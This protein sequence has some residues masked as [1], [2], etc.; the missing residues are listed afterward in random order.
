[1]TE[2]VIESEADARAAIDLIV[3][4][5]DEDPENVAELRRA[6]SE[7]CFWLKAEKV[8]HPWT[9]TSGATK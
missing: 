5:Y 7:S 4:F 8:Q 6:L 3:E 2:I 1:M 9:R